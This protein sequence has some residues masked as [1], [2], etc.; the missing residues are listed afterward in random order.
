VIKSD[1]C[2][3]GQDPMDCS[4]REAAFRWASGRYRKY[5]GRIIVRNVEL[6]SGGVVFAFFTVA[7]A[8]R[9]QRYISLDRF[10][11]RFTF[12][13]AFIRETIKTGRKDGCQQPRAQVYFPGGVFT[14]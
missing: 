8:D 12:V 2:L 13:S 5:T 11:R 3:P 14:W 9:I 7:L 4:D 10:R 1:L 6:Y